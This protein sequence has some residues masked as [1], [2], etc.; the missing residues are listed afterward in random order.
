MDTLLQDLRFAART[1]RARP[2]FTLMAVATL[3]LGIGG[4]TAIFSLVDAVLLGALPYSDADRLF[5]VWEDATVAGFPRNDVAPG[6]Y[7]SLQAQNRVF[8]GMAAVAQESFN[9]TGDGEPL[10]RSRRVVSAP[11]S[12]L[13]SGSRPR[14]VASFGPRKTGPGPITWRS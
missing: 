13:S 14:S 10:R 1:L 11:A 2:G 3:A 12:S 9:L 6:N 7:A 5:M 8:E 4:S